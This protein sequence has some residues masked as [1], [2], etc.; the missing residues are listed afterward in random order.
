MKAK[1]LMSSPAVTVRASTAIKEV[2]TVLR[3]RGFNAVPVVDRDEALIGIVSEADL[4]RM[5]IDMEAELPCSTV[6]SSGRSSRPRT[7]QDV[8]TREVIFAT[9]NSEVPRIA[10][11]MVDGDIRTVPVVEHDRVVGVVT[12]G[13]L[14]KVFTRS[15]DAIRGELM[16]LFDSELLS[17]RFRV[18]VR[19]GIVT[20]AGWGDHGARHLAER[21]ARRQLGV[22]DVEFRT[23]G[24]AGPR[25]GLRERDRVETFKHRDFWG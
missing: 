25:G 11:T 22:I 17:L 6:D 20:L 19:D 18:E 12:R 10:R 16:D 7:A 23:N 8:M 2:A 3:S 24:E 5:E 1:E 21:I 4:V 13:D 9:P 14:I 15:D